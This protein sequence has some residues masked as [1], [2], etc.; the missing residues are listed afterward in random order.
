MRKILFAW[1]YALSL[2]FKDKYVLVLSLFPI[3]ISMIL[4]FSLGGWGLLEVTSSSKE[5]LMSFFSAD[6]WILN[7]LLWI[8]GTVAVA[9]LYFIGSF[10]FLLLV[11]LFSCFFSDAISLRVE[12]KLINEDNFSV[13]ESLGQSLRRLP[14][15]IMNESKKVFLIAI[16]ITLS[17]IM[18]LS[19]VLMPLALLFTWAL[20]AVQFLDYSWCRH[21][22]TFSEC[23]QDFKDHWI[24][25]ALCG[26][27]FSF[28]LAIPFLGIFFFSFANI[29]FTVLFVRNQ[30]EEEL[31][32]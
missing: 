21:Q 20:V 4:I 25:Y 29:F 32:E 13:T 5:W 1:N 10:L 31:S 15:I 12:R 3:L 22:L 9:S 16:L 17:A 6:S 26:F 2:Q 27:C 8:V 23:I 18:G 7:I 11:S 19:G 24:S 28:F 30:L 14:S